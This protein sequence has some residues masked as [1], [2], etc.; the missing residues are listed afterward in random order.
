MFQL[1]EVAS[2]RV[3]IGGRSSLETEAESRGYCLSM[4]QPEL[5]LTCAS[6]LPPPP[7]PNP[8]PPPRLPPS[9][10]APPMPPP[11]PPPPSPPVAKVPLPSPESPPPYE[12]YVAPPGYMDHTQCSAMLA[13]QG[14]RLH[15]LWGPEGWRVRWPDQEA[16]WPGDGWDFFDNACTSCRWGKDCARNWYTGNQG[17]LGQQNGGPDKDWVNPHFTAPAPALLGFDRN[18]N[19]HCR[20][21]SA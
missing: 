6:S 2:F 14:N 17:G 3:L 19:W 9:L 18:I 7:P 12:G 5:G 11:S 13:D 10:P 1:Q 8:S 21:S 4:V 15:Q 16:C 20:K